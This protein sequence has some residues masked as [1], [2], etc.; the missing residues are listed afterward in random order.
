MC[1]SLEW[2]AVAALVLRTTGCIKSLKFAAP[3]LH[4]CLAHGSCRQEALHAK[5]PRL[6]WSEG[7][8][9]VRWQ[10]SC[11]MQRLTHDSPLAATLAALSVVH[12]Q[13]FG[14]ESSLMRPFPCILAC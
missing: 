10:S 1:G 7:E 2:E 12:L 13:S 6:Q 3:T 8:R 11:G 14:L 9:N 4:S 5:R